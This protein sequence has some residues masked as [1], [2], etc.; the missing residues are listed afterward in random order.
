MISSSVSQNLPEDFTYTAH[1]GCVDTADNSLEAIEKGVQYGAKIVEFDLHFTQ[2]G[3]PVLSHDAP[4]GGEVTLDAAFECVSRYEGLRVNV[5]VKSGTALE[6]VVILA[7]KHGLKDRIFFTGLFEDDI[8]LVQN[9][10]PGI[11]YWL[12]EDVL[13]VAEHSD[14]YLQQ[15]VGLVRTCKAVG[16]NMNK[17][18]ATKE[19]VDFFRTNGLGVSLWTVNEEEEMLK[20]L[21]FSPDNI[22][23]RRPDTMQTLLK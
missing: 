16:I 22:T 17:N 3:T 18:N 13:P 6:K 9:A 4:K 8:P 20:Y 10:C 14:A 12:N 1:T 11:P 2:D 23:T 19:L 15:L 7:E 21:S 5:D